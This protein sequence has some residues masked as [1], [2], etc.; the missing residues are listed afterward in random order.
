MIVR[1]IF[2]DDSA[3]KVNCSI[4]PTSN[5]DANFDAISSTTDME[6]IPKS[7]ISFWFSNNPI[8]TSLGSF[9]SK[10]FL[11]I[12][13]SDW[14]RLLPKMFMLYYSQASQDVVKGLVVMWFYHIQIYI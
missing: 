1:Q 2:I 8:I 13:Y 5:F 6:E 7:I 14:N 12:W 9:S 11:R 3:D 10:A 4:G